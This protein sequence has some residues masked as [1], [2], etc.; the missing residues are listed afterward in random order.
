MIVIPGRPITKKN[1][2]QISVNKRTLK[3]RVRQSEAYL[4]Y[5]EA[6][7][8]HLKKYKQRHNGKVALCARYYMPNY[9]SWPDLIGLL[10]ATCDILEK[11]QIIE[12]DRYVVR[13]DGSEIVGVDKQKPRVEVIIEEVKEVE[14]EKSL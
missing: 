6:S 12:N 13:L 2:Q 4:T 3:P 5:E 8:W 7:L 9:A 11:S 14:Y 10:Q 1:S